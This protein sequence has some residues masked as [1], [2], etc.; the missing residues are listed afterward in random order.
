MGLIDGGDLFPNSITGFVTKSSGFVSL[1][2]ACFMYMTAPPAQRK[3]KPA[4]APAITPSLGRLLSVAVVGAQVGDGVGAGVG[5]AVV[6]GAGV[7]DGVGVG[8][9]SS[10]LAYLARDAFNR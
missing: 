1:F 8:V 10:S 3:I 5:T 4:T 7:G 9:G 6:V 2:L